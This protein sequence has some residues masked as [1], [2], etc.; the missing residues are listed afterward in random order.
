MGEVGRSFYRPSNHRLERSGWRRP[1]GLTVRRTSEMKL[2]A[3]Q[4]VANTLPEMLV[5]W[6]MSEDLDRLADLPNGVLRIDVLREVAVHSK[7]GPVELHIVLELSAWLRGRL[8]ALD[9]PVSQLHEVHVEADIRTDRIATDRKRIVLF[10]FD[11]RSRVATRAEGLRGSTQG[12]HKWH[13]RV[14][15]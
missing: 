1:L 12:E 11:C 9:I 5:G 3:L 14:G 4:G 15:A 2:K 10:D 13:R 6:R 7:A 8:T